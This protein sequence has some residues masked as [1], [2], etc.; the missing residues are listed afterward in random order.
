MHGQV[1]QRQTRTYTQKYTHLHIPVRLRCW[2]PR[3][4]WPSRCPRQTEGR[5]PRGCRSAR[6]GRTPVWCGVVG[7][8]ESGERERERGQHKS[9]GWCSDTNSLRVFIQ[10]PYRQRKTIV[11]IHLQITYQ[12]QPHHKHH[13]NSPSGPARRC[14]RRPAC[15]GCS[16]R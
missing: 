1:T 11:H 16:G 6:K 9:V 15:R 8:V 2:R 7:G 4:R 14:P 10:H 3:R 13:C 12:T 5:A